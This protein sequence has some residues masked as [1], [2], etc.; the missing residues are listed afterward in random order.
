MSQSKQPDH[1]MT[2]TSVTKGLIF[3]RRDN[4][5]PIP[6]AM[7]SGNVE[8]KK[9]TPTSSTEDDS[10]DHYFRLL[11]CGGLSKKG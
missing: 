6:P 11:G 3:R 1:P 2:F 7:Q 4:G 9:D 8:G 5:W 10:L